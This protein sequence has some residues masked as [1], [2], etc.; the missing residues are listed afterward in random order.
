MI[1]VVVSGFQ[2]HVAGRHEDHDDQVQRHPEPHGTQA[3]AEAID[4]GGVKRDL[5]AKGEGRNE[6]QLASAHFANAC[7]IFLDRG[8]PE[9]LPDNKKYCIKLRYI[10]AVLT[11]AG[12]QAQWHRIIESKKHAKQA[13]CNNPP[14]IESI[15]LFRR[16]APAVCA[17][18]R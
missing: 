9:Q 11:A 17:G 2:V 3:T 5:R 1:V 8:H 12:P 7:Q 4:P 16:S 13:T 6:R 18:R 10:P 14:I 15:E